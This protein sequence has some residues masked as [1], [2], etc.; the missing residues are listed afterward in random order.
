MQERP[1]PSP[2]SVETM[3]ASVESQAGLI[4][5]VLDH[6][7]PQVREI[8]RQLEPASVAE[9]VTAGCGDSLYAAIGAR[10]AFE[11]H[12]GL[13]M[14]PLE[15]LEF[16]RYTV[17]HLSRGAIVIG[18]SAGGDKS[19][20]IEAIKEAN[21]NGLRTIAIVG[22]A[23]S[24][25]ATEANFKILQNERDTRPSP[26]P[27]TSG[28]FALGN[29][30][31]SLV[32]LFAIAFELGL[33]KG[34]LSTDEYH[35]LRQHVLDAAPIIEATAPSTLEAV[36]A[37]AVSVRDLTAMY[38]LGGGP[39]HATALFGAA[40]LFEMPQALGVP[41]ELE[42]WA[43][44]QYFLTRPDSA[45]IVVAPPGASVD[46]ARE[47]LWGARTMGARTVVVCD[48]EDHVTQESADLAFG[49]QGALPEEFSAL[50]Y[51]IPL[52][53]C[54]ALLCEAR[55]QAAFEFI[56]DLQFNVNMHQIGRSA[57]RVGP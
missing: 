39:S 8:V 28:V 45:V 5:A 16:S 35:A 38:I 52:E 2:V 6:V 44:E 30:L 15:A 36:R 54:A 7:T 55:G 42:E 20:T 10:L 11:K 18:I 17:N 31:A 24:P 43:H 22:V 3:L 48:S 29:Y 49:I 26:I 32:T 14:E 13:R 19:R 12:S 9:V 53:Q 23:D 34:R 4:R 27:E 33:A 37:Y 57:L 1:A 40:K 21:R 25:L 50:T 56:S 47:Q 51:S 41:V 46:R